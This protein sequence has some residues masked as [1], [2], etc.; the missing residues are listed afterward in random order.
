MFP[1]HDS[2]PAAPDFDAPAIQIAALTALTAVSI[3]L[4]AAA[5]AVSPDD[6]APPDVAA[7][8]AAVARAAV[9]LADLARWAGAAG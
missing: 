9:L 5:D 1:M 7:F 6:N 4:E 2:T 3:E 8:R